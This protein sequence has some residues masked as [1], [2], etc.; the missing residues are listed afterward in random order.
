M[1][2]NGRRF[3]EGIDRVRGACLV[4]GTGYTVTGRRFL[5][6]GAE[7]AVEAREGGRG[8]FCLSVRL[9]AWFETL[10]RFYEPPI[11]PIAHLSV[12]RV[13]TRG[14]VTRRSFG[15]LSS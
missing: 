2:K 6:A 10:Q 13:V 9:F 15:C 3:A 7:L 14:D 1:E 5:E 4:A 8:W 11:S 12:L